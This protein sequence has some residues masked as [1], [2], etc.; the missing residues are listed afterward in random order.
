MDEQSIPE[1]LASILA[2]VLSNDV[3]IDPTNLEA[4]LVTDYGADSMDMV[5]IADGIEDEFGFVV[6]NDETESLQSFGSIIE[7]ILRNKAN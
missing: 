2:D 7:L 1:R 6:Q 3:K 4:R 5:D